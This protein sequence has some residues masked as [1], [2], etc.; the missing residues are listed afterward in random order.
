MADPHD[1]DEAARYLAAEPDARVEDPLRRA[2][3]DEVRALLADPAMWEQPPPALEE[4]TVAAVTGAAEAQRAAGHADR[5]PAADAD[6]LGPE[7]DLS[8]LEAVLDRI[9]RRL[10]AD[11]EY[12]ELFRSSDTQATTLH[13]AG[14]TSALLAGALADAGAEESELVAFAMDG[15]EG[16]PATATGTDAILVNTICTSP[17]PDN[18]SCRRVTLSLRIEVERPGD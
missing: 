16:T 14:V 15:S 13:S 3:L 6:P 10:A 9:G 11:P 5:G 17:G 7:L 2:E 4:R 1:D 8:E 12:R 18:D